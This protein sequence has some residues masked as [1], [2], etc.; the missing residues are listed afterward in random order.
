MKNYLKKCRTMALVA[1]FAILQ[2]MGLYSGENNQGMVFA[3]KNYINDFMCKFGYVDVE[4]REYPKAYLNG[5]IGAIPQEVADLIAQLKNPQDYINMRVRLTKGLIF[6]GPPGSG[7]T[8]LARSIASELYCPFIAANATDFKQPHIGE[9]SQAVTA[10]FEQ[11]RNAARQHHS[12][13]AI[14]FID[15]FDAVGTRVGGEYDAGR[16]EV[17]NTLLNEMDGFNAHDDANVIVIAATNWLRLI[18]PALRR[19]GR[20]DYKVYI[21]YPDQEGRALF[22]EKFLQHYPSDELIVPGDLVKY[23]AG[24][25]PADMK[26]LFELAGRIAVRSKKSKRDLACFKEALYRM[27]YNVG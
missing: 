5:Y 9:G 20:F 26:F 2:P 6:Y 10:L 12:G 15:E 4:H 27:R 3:L 21:P 1:F 7:K 24:M 16:S 18:D 14:L 23:T 25:S 13:T 17:I 22:I 8:E 11:A 19:C